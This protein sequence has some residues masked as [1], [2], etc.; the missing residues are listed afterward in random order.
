MISIEFLLGQNYQQGGPP[1][2]EQGFGCHRWGGTSQEAR[3]KE[4]EVETRR[5]SATGA[6]SL[7]SS[8]TGDATL[9]RPWARMATTTD[10]MV[11][12]F[13]VEG[14][15]VCGV[16]TFGWLRKDGDCVREGK[17]L[18]RNPA[19]KNLLSIYTQ[20]ELARTRHPWI[21]PCDVSECQQDTHTPTTVDV[22]Q[23]E[24]TSGNNAIHRYA[25]MYDDDTAVRRDF[26]PEVGRDA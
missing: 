4:I 20:L 16:V 21:S 17:K 2:F 14:L 11:V 6:A 8:W 19:R 12:N 1:G 10:A 26:I 25:S 18:E 7:A 15:G 5:T 9:S 24:V 3:S 23:E 22:H 13:M